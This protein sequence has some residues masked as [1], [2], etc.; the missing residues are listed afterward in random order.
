MGMWRGHDGLR[1]S[2]RHTVGYLSSFTLQVSSMSVELEAS[3]AISSFQHV[4]IDQIITGLAHCPIHNFE[5]V[6]NKS[7]VLARMA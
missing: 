5:P 2:A 1:G 4:D 3:H 7:R 6:P